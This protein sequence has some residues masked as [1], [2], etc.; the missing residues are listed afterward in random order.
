MNESMIHPATATPALRAA[1]RSPV[2]SVL[3]CSLIHLEPDSTDSSCLFCCGF[4]VNGQYVQLHT[5]TSAGSWNIAASTGGASLGP[6][7]AMAPPPH[8]CNFI[9]VATVLI[10]TEPT[11]L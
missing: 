2:S 4:E 11:N 9:E 10:I 5:R 3:G 8:F 6:Q 7:W 1:R